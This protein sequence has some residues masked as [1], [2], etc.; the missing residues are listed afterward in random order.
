MLSQETPTSSRVMHMLRAT[1]A[2]ERLFVRVALWPLS[3]DH[4][5]AYHTHL[6]P[7]ESRTRSRFLFRVKASIQARI[8][9]PTCVASTA[10]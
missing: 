8:A 1:L 2:P 3:M 4:T 10:P 5:A 9:S 7:V 6:D